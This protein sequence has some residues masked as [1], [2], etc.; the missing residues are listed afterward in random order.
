MR[1]FLSLI[2]ASAILISGFALAAGEVIRPQGIRPFLLVGEFLKRR[3][4]LRNDNAAR[5]I[6]RS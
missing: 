1:R 2:M 6:G 3:K 5:Q 4:G